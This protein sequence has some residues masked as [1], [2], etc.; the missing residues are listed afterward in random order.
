MAAS[1]LP[2][3]RQEMACSLLLPPNTTATRGRLGALGALGALAVIARP[4][5]VRGSSGPTLPAP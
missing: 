2:A 3:V 4:P 5:A 1:T